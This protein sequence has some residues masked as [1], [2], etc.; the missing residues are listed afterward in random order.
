MD[1]QSNIVGKSGPRDSK[2]TE[3]YSEWQLR[4]DI[5][6]RWKRNIIILLTLGVLVSLV[7]HLI[8]AFTLAISDRNLK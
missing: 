1:E 4:S 2:H 3:V 5:N 7:L 8:I 6:Y